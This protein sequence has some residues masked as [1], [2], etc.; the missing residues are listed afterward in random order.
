MSR[1]LVYTTPP[2]WAQGVRAHADELLIEQAHLEKKAAAAASTFLFRVPTS[3]TLQRE[4]SRLAREELVHF[5]RTLRL[6]EQRGLAFAAQTPCAY[7][8]RLKAVVSRDMPLRLCDELLVAAVIEARSHERMELLAAALRERDPEL[9][10]FY[11]DLVEAEGRHCGIYVEAAEAAV[12]V[13]AVHERWPVVTAYEAAVVRSL[14]WSPR[15]HGGLRQDAAVVD[16]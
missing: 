6:L 10:A 16:G 7:A 8:E 12:S 14:P 11:R 9:A 4:L 15:L 5:E 1:S 13:A 3:A 2:T